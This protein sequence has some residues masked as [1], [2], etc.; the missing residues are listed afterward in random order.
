M[1]GTKIVEL[2]APADPT[3]AVQS[4]MAA[5]LAVLCKMNVDELE[6]VKW[7]QKKALSASGTR[8]TPVDI[9]F[10]RTILWL[11]ILDLVMKSSAE[12]ETDNFSATRSL[13]SYCS[14][15]CD[16][17]GFSDD[18]GYT[19]HLVKISAVHMPKPEANEAVRQASAD[20]QKAARRAAFVASK[21]TPAWDK[22]KEHASSAPI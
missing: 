7:P 8:K 1:Y 15:I 3:F 18:F 14:A 4:M 6:D 13:C 17:F 22:D 9:T 21:G 16:Q 12:S 11:L 10:T 2:S 20:E 5:N 19:L